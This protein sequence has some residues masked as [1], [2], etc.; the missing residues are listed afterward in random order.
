MP[1]SA[2]RSLL[3][4][5]SAV[6]TCSAV[7]GKW[8]GVLVSRLALLCAHSSLTALL[9]TVGGQS[10]GQTPHGRGF[11]TS[12]GY[13]D[14]AEDHWTQ[15]S[16]CCGECNCPCTENTR[17]PQGPML[18]AAGLP[19]TN[20][21][22]FWCTD[23][24]CWGENGTDYHMGKSEQVIG[25]FKHYGDCKCTSDLITMQFVGHLQ[26]IACAFRRVLAGGHAHHL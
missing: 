21:I 1:P 20:A 24:P 6:V 15:A 16:C 18:A 12:K 4:G 17:G 13:T 3:T 11:D 14:G 26:H 8:H 2:D 19:A 9:F 25:D 7:V 23:K 5:Q 22:D 10:F